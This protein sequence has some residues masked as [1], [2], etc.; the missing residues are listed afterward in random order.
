M[1]RRQEREQ[2]FI[3]IFERLFR[4]DVDMVTIFEMAEESEFMIPSEFSK[5]LSTVVDE[6]DKD[7]DNLVQEVSIG[8]NTSRMSKVALAI[9][10]LAVAEMK[11]FEDIP[12]S[13]SINEAVELAKKYASTEDASFVNGVLGT[14][15]RRQEQ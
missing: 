9:I 3:L 5:K 2:A 7:I 15:A 1:N 8:W 4:P 10:R 13:V 6:N 14:I 11:F 12:V